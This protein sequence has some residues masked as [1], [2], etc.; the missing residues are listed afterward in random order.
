MCITL[1]EFAGLSVNYDYKAISDIHDGDI[2]NCGR[3]KGGLGILW[4]NEFKSV[5]KSVGNSTN[6]I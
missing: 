1:V 2:V 3:P 6:G 4:R 5:I